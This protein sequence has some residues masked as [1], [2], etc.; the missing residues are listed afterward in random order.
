MRAP[1]RGKLPG[2]S[3]P[4]ALR[5]TPTGYDSFGVGP[6]EHR[7]RRVLD[8][9]VRD[10]FAKTLDRRDRRSPEFGAAGERPLDVTAAARVVRDIIPVIIDEHGFDLPAVDC[11]VEIADL[12]GVVDGQAGT[13]SGARSGWRSGCQPNSFGKRRV[14]ERSS[15]RY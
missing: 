13:Y 8:H 7:A 11:R 15:L 14:G 10:P 2:L 12:P 1:P 5:R 4:A 3:R 9:H 6:G